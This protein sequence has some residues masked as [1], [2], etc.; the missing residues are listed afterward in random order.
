WPVGEDPQAAAGRRAIHQPQIDA[1]PVPA[2]QPLAAAQH[3]RMQPQLYSSTRSC[4]SSVG[5]S[6]ELPRTRTG[7]PGS[8][9]S[10]ATSTATSPVRM[11]VPGQAV[12]RSVV[13]TTY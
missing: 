6:V 1:A 7:P 13:D 8:C 12:S 4:A 5:T 2:E 10:L 9:F 3:D 11:V